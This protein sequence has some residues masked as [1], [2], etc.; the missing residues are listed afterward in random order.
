MDGRPSCKKIMRERSRVS[1][2]IRPSQL[3]IDVEVSSL[4][5]SWRWSN[6]A[7]LVSGVR[8][9]PPSQHYTTT[10]TN[11][12]LK[13]SNEAI[14]YDLGAVQNL[15]NW[16]QTLKSLVAAGSVGTWLLIDLAIPLFDTRAWRHTNFNSTYVVHVLAR[17]AYLSRQ[18]AFKKSPNCLHVADS[19]LRYLLGIL[20]PVSAMVYTLE[21]SAIPEVLLDHPENASNGTTVYTISVGSILQPVPRKRG[22]SYINHFVMFQVTAPGWFLTLFPTS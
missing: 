11:Q 6:V 12:P 16:W 22:F 21:T 19:L 14:W 17:N 13:P 5:R 20:P 7:F 8:G 2:A 15:S 4:Q 3:W 1:T 18:I 10:I 9:R